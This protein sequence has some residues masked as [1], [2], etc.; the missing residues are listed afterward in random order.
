MELVTLD[1]ETYYDKDY[2]LS[3]LTTE[4]YI[5][6][7]RFQIIGVGVK[8]G[9]KPP[10]WYSPG[11]DLKLSIVLADLN[12][13]MVLCH[14]T[15]FDAAILSWRLGIKPR[16]LLDTLSMARAVLGGTEKHSLAALAERYGLGAKG[17]EVL[18]AKGKRRE[19]FSPAEMYKYA[20]YC[21]NDVELTHK[22]FKKL[23]AG[24]PQDELRTIDMTLRMF[25]DPVLCLDIPTIQRESD[26]EQH[27]KDTLLSSLGG[28]I[29]AEDLRSND[30]F[31]EVLRS[32]GVDPPTKVS[33]KTG[34]TTWAFA[35]N[36]ADFKA[37]M[38]HDDPM[39]QAAVE[40][41]LGHKST[42]KATRAARFMGI[43]KRMGKLPVPL[44]YYSAHTGRYGG[45]DGINMQN[46]PR[47]SKKDPDS[48][49]LRKAIIAP[50]GHRL[51]VAD[52][53]QIEARLLVWQAGQEDKI[54]AFAQGRDIYSE[55]ASV[56][57]SRKVD[58]KKNPDDFVPGFIGKA[59]VLGCGFGL[60]HPKF[61]G[62]INVGMLG[63]PRLLFDDEF[64]ERMSVD[65]G[66]Y[67]RRLA[68]DEDLQDRIEAV[69]PA[70][71]PSETWL[72]HMACADHIIN[73]YRA[74]N[75]MVKNYWSVAGEAIMAMYRGERFEFG[76]PSG[77]LLT[78]EQS[79][80]VLPN[81]LK[82]LYPGLERKDGE[83]SCLRKK[84][85]RVQRV[86]L[87]GGAV[88]ENCIAGGTQVLTN[89][90][91][92]PIERVTRQDLVHD[93]LEFVSHGGVVY[94]SA[95]KCVK[96]DGVY[97]TPDHEVLTDE[98]WK[99]AL[100]EPRPYRPTIRQA[101]STASG[102][103]RREED[104]LALR[105]FLRE[106]GGESRIGSNE[107]SEKGEQHRHAQLRLRHAYCDQHSQLFPWHEPA[108][109][110]LGL[111]KH[112]RSVQASIASRM[113][114]LRSAWDQCVRSV[115]RLVRGFLGGY[116][117]DVQARPVTGSDR[118]QWSVFPGELQ[119]GRPNHPSEQPSEYGCDSHSARGDGRRGSSAGVR[120][121]PD[122]PDL[123]PGERMA[124][125]YSVDDQALAEEQDVYD[126]VNCGPRQRFVVRGDGGPFIVHNCTQALARIVI[127]D[128]M[129]AVERELGCRVVLQVHDEIVMVAP[130]ETAESVY[131]NAIRIMRT[132][133][134][135]AAG[136]PL[137]AEGG[138]AT[139]YG[140]AK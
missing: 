54:Q 14:N 105:V 71:I 17:K 129:L 79:A 5:N 123:S 37:L 59:V 109:R 2:S 122:D 126:I 56:I 13:H 24:F 120:T 42:Q 110:V 128:N 33:A 20:K 135:W 131:E 53:S 51:V 113:E 84:E 63:G 94:K 62:M 30:K 28:H 76:G 115:G 75:Q 108:S 65:V 74:D 66:Y 47:A 112:A 127:R 70:A 7:P 46:L 39:V 139:R 104:A 8:Y 91:W 35:K 116:G 72:T 101:D 11:D 25:T 61:G 4:E 90:G 136:L 89:S 16:F 1:F 134:G 38:E 3:K 97:M 99:P 117:A 103:E 44:A 50:P 32:L 119:V 106:Q 82:L 67:A 86:K 130:E 83:F 81:G 27:R 88:V 111:A 100:E 114:E 98:G 21:M 31:A 96:V 57:Y 9:D 118:Q 87:Y 124:R 10:R 85:G 102:A 12:N 49:L 140:D 107:V 92:K 15:M 78:T 23:G 45:T 22:L 19:D 93:G 6:D 68:R 80:I 34:K 132:P 41:R 55:Q 125:G 121:E 40:A 133:P 29:Q 52:L 26:L 58:R 48:G 73:T 138:V 69:R 77:D 18:D 36:D 60:G 95:Q 64:V 137:D 43:A